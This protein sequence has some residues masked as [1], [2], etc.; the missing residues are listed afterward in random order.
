MSQVKILIVDDHKVMRTMI[1]KMLDPEKF[2]V[3]EAA[4]A[5]PASSRLCPGCCDSAQ[6]WPGILSP[7]ICA[8]SAM[9][10]DALAPIRRPHATRLP[11]AGKA[12]F[13]GN[14]S[15]S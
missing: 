4:E 9:A 10:S 13:R 8:S 11:P 7:A 2:A 14:S 15:G 3:S 12:K 1:R 6:K 5:A